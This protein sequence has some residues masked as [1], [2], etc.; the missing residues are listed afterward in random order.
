MLTPIAFPEMRE[1]LLEQSGGLSFQL[2]E[3]FR[4]GGRRIE[5]G[6]DVDMVGTD[7]AGEDFG[8]LLRTD[9]AYEVTGPDGDIVL[10]YFVPIF[11]DPDDM[12]LDTENAMR[13]CPVSFGH[14]TRIPC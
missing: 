6:K 12:D 11:R 5:G 8:A 13:R 1:F 4:Y 9:T 2:L 14:E 3:Q 7:D 10:Q